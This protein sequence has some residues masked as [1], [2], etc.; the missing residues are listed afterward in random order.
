[1]A[2]IGVKLS[3]LRPSLELGGAGNAGGAMGIDEEVMKLD[4]DGE[5]VRAT[6]TFGL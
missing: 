5:T 3:P 1:M 2:A 4:D 6:L